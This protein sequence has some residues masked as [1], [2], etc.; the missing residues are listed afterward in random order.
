ML[1][2]V[3]S[4]CTAQTATP[5]PPKTIFR[6]W[7]G[8]LVSN[9]EF[10]EIRMANYEVKDRTIVKT[11]SDGTIEFNLA[12]IPQEG[13]RSPAF[14]A[15]T[16]DGRAVSLDSLKGKVVVLNFWFIGCAYCRALQPKLNVFKAKFGSSEDVVFLAM[17]P[18]P[19]RELR[20]YLA[21]EKFDFIHIADAQPLL[22][23]FRFTGYP[24]NIVI[25][26]TGEIVYWRSTVHAWDKFESV[27]RSELAK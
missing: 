9:N 11:L 6:D 2:C 24:K 21:K 20:Q 18:D 1:L 15:L 4:P 12:K 13:T 19:V 26:K 5:T 16:I 17:S 23:S 27:I 8:E 3:A 14:S 25:S 10:V 22:S 7:N